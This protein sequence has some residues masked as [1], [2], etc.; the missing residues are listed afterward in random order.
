M[1]PI[2]LSALTSV[3]HS[4]ELSQSQI[5]KKMCLFPQILY[6]CKYPKVYPKYTFLVI[7]QIILILY[8]QK[9]LKYFSCP[10]ICHY[11]IQKYII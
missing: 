11:R 1:F 4:T 8:F 2:L 3:R 5:W 9:V 6:V 10:Q 7:V